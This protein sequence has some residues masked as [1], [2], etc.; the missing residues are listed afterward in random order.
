MHWSL[1]VGYAHVIALNTDAWLAGDRSAQQAVIAEQLT[2]LKA[3]LEAASTLEQRAK[4]PWIIAFG[5]EMM[6]ST[7]D[8]V[9]VG[10]GA[11]LRTAFEDLFHDHGV[12]LYFAGHEHVYVR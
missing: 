6:Y 9:H 8:A 7:H 1:D 3:D 10:Q 2:W 12:D 5:H 11:I 4:V